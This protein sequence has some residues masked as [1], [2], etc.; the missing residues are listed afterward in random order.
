LTPADLSSTFDDL[1]TSLLTT[2]DDVISQL[3]DA[4]G[5]FISD[6]GILAP[7]ALLLIEEA[8][9]PLPVPGDV[10]VMYVGHHIST[11]DI[12]WYIAW[13]GLIAT[14]VAGSS[15]L[16]WLARWKGERLV[17]KVGRFMHI[18]DRSMRRAES[19]FN[20]R[21]VL[22]IIFG[23]HIP[24]VRIPITLAAGTLKFSYPLF[25]ASVAVS[26]AV[27]AGVFLIVG[28]TLGDRAIHAILHPHRG[29]TVVLVLG[30]AGLAAA[31]ILLRHRSR[32]HAAPGP[33]LATGTS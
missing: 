4:I 22:A 16:Y 12:D 20:K 18:N 29:S 26:T 9:L 14:V 21:G 23:R 5:G 27:W 1:T 19:W 2:G 33:A 30:L 10:S 25:V 28:A 32:R 7:F 8:G 11:G 24:G 15:L 17:K 13:L 6:N 3:S 31:V